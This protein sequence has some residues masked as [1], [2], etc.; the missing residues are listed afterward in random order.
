MYTSNYSNIPWVVPSGNFTATLSEAK[1]VKDGTKEGVR[2][3]FKIPRQGDLTED[4]MAGVTFDHAYAQ[5][6]E[7]HLTSWLG[8][9]DLKQIF[10]DGAVTEENLRKLVG[11]D[12]VLQIRSLQKG[13]QN[14][15]SAIEKILNPKSPSSIPSAAGRVVF[16]LPGLHCGADTGNARHMCVI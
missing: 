8:H 1:V 3:T 16:R 5:K 7:A 12:A 14:P 11:R 15:F 2:L 9:A 4:K 10:P 6:L 13:Q